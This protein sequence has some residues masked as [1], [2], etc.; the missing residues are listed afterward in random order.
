MRT[1]TIAGLFDGQEWLAESVDPTGWLAEPATGIDPAG[2]SPVVLSVGQQDATST[3]DVADRRADG[4]RTSGRA[5]RRARRVRHLRRVRTENLRSGGVGGK[6]LAR[7]GV[8]RRAVGRLDGL[9]R[10]GSSAV[11]PPSVQ[12]ALAGSTAD[13]SSAIASTAVEY[14]AEGYQLGRWARL[15]LTVTALAAIAVVIVS[16]TAG[17]AP[18][19]MVDVTVV[20]GDTLWSIAAEA[21]PDRDPRDVIEEIRQLNDMQGGVLPIGVVLRVPASAD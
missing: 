19:A 6:T 21:A 4:G 9:E 2:G 18:Q 10:T 11:R 1:Q 20:P 16:L 3:E 12:P 7:H 13:G 17:S 15:A 8:G 5:A 14:T